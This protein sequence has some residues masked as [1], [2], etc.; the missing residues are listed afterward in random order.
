M[1]YPSSHLLLT[2]HWINANHP[3]ETGQ[4]GVRFFSPHA[5][6]QQ[7]V[8]ACKATVQ[9]FWT[10]AGNI[11]SDYALQFIR[12][13]RIGASGVYSNESSFDA[14]FGTAGIGLGGATTAGAYPLQIACASTLL[15]AVPHGQAAK[16]R[17]YLPPIPGALPGGLMW[18]AAQVNVRSAAL[19]A[20]LTSLG[21]ILGGPAR[22]FSKGVQRNTNGVSR[23][24]VAVKTGQRPDVQRR[25]A[26]KVLEVYGASSSVSPVPADAGPAEDIGILTGP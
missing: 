8:D 19:A 16:G 13:A 25:R 4:S 11:G 23:D 24:V 21:P 14:T 20:M 2:L 26:K 7:R 18:T 3:E 12:L 15:T 22:V 9:T 5:T 6:T 1:P 10:T 17:M